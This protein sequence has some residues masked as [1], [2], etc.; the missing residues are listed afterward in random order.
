[1]TSERYL[2]GVDVGT[3]SA[4]AGLF[5]VGGRM[6]ASATEPIKMWKPAPNHAEQCSED[7]WRAV[8][9]CTKSVLKQAGIPAFAVAGISFDATCSLVVLDAHDAPLPVNEE[10]VAARNVIVWMDHRAASEADEINV[11]M[12]DVLTFVGGNISP[13]MEI[14]KLLWLKRHLPKNSGPTRNAESH[15]GHSTPHGPYAVH[16]HYSRRRVSC[17]GG[18][19]LRGTVPPAQ[20][21]SA[22]AAGP[23]ARFPARPCSSGGRRFIGAD[24]GPVAVRTDHRRRATPTPVTH[25]KPTYRLLRQSPP[26]IHTKPETSVRDLR[27]RKS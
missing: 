27:V 20:P 2:V 23:K 22:S 1:M 4:R 3:G 17:G 11:G 6:L 21:E 12:H 10:G 5:D 16:P 15:H 18:G 7:I 9:K 25:C 13:E 26:V 14:P 19:R 8:G 24:E